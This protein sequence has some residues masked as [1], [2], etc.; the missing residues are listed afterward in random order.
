MR[1]CAPERC[2][3][4]GPFHVEVLSTAP[5]LHFIQ[6]RH[7]A[8]FFS[9]AIAS[10]RPSMISCKCRVLGTV[11]EEDERTV[12]R[13]MTHL[14]DAAPDVEAY[15]PDLTAAVLPALHAP[16][17][18]VRS[19]GCDIVSRFLATS[20][21]GDRVLDVAGHLPEVLAVRSFSLILS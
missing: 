10:W 17:F 15:L 13:A 5:P 21:D 8:V 19:L 6:V 18:A 11:T 14:V 3:W 4:G 16:S 12:V 7:G 20:D 9:Q 2:A 1:S